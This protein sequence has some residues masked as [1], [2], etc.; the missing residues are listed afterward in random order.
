MQTD[1]ESYVAGLSGMAE[2]FQACLHD[3]QSLDQLNANLSFFIS[4]CCPLSFFFANELLTPSMYVP[5]EGV[6]YNW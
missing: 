1:E 4:F 6:K 3:L 2:S 5:Y